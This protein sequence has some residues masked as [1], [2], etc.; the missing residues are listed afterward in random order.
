MYL[1]D[2]W[3]SDSGTAKKVEDV[4]KQYGLR[5]TGNYGG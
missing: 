1:V 5:V 4:V 3:T 2:F